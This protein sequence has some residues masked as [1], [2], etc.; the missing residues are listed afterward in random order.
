MLTS[1]YR[2]TH[3][4]D[5]RK[6]LLSFVSALLHRIIPGSSDFSGISSHEEK[7][8]KSNICSDRRAKR[9]PQSPQAGV[10]HCSSYQNLA[11]ITSTSSAPQSNL[12]GSSAYPSQSEI[13]RRKQLPLNSS[14]PLWKQ[15][16]RSFDCHFKPFHNHLQCFVK[17]CER[18]RGFPPQRKDHYNVRGEPIS[19]YISGAPK[20]RALRGLSTLVGKNS[21]NE[22]Q[23]QDIGI[24]YKELKPWRETFLGH[25]P[26]ILDWFQ[27][28]N[29]FVIHASGRLSSRAFE[30]TV[31]S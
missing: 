20:I 21:S 12:V 19:N 25:N 28:P 29:T 1:R 27:A 14:F 26:T 3:A 5:D 7:E 30:L 17:G 13:T 31:K 24:F 18:L 10:Q 16:H 6:D 15:V 8:S 4:S 23:A 11:P 2:A 22:F 9:R